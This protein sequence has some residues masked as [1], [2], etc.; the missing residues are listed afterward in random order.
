MCKNTSGV[1]RGVSLPAF[2]GRYKYQEGLRTLL[3][4]CRKQ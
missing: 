2:V 4:L 3:G 1:W